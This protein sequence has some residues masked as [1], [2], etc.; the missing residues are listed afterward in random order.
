MNL[1]WLRESL[2]LHRKRYSN[3]RGELARERKEARAGG[4][5][6]TPGLVTAEE[7]ARIHEDEAR[8][9]KE[10]A[11][12]NRRKKQIAAASPDRVSGRPREAF[13]L[14]VPNCS[15]RGGVRPRIIVLHTTESSNQAGT[16]DLRAIG[17]WFSNPKAQSSSH[18]GVDAEGNSC[19]YV[20]DHLKAWT[21]ASYNPQALSI[22]QIGRAAQQDWTD[23][24]LRKTAQYIA[25]WSA[26]Y[27]I[28]IRKS[29]VHGVCEHVHLGAAGGGHHDCGA[30]YPFDKVL[31]LARSMS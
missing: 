8:V 21:Q 7:A 6:R 12:I 4:S 19:Q 5:G 9:Q 11:L 13:R 27:G 30:K 25:Y 28:P 29:T 16:G 1:K 31:A 26:K 23:A 17:A 3:A 15:S 10:L 20:P 22:E 18:V 24:Q 2:G 14:T